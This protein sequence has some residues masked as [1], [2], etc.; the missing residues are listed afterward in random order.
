MTLLDDA[1]AEPAAADVT[2]TWL[3]TVPGDEPEVNPEEATVAA[4]ADALA[5]FLSS[6]GDDV[7]VEATSRPISAGAVARWF[8]ALDAFRAE[9]WTETAGSSADS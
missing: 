4:R 8:E 2:E 3:L 5:A 1:R 9:H 6:W 7:S